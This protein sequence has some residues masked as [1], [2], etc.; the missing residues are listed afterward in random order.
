M[1]VAVEVVAE[2][3]SPRELAH[4]VALAG[5]D[6]CHSHPAVAGP[7]GSPDPVNVCVMV[8]RRVEV[9]DV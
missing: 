6:E 7:S 2:A 5:A 3:Q 8:A 9:D 4:V 1:R